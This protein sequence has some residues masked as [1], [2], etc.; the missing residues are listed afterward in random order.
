MLGT[1]ATDMI[2]VLQLKEQPC[3]QN[4]FPF[5]VGEKEIKL[6]DNMFD[7]SLRSPVSI[8][9]FFQKEKT[10]VKNRREKN[11]FV[12]ASNCD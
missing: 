12:N 11:Y 6:Y 9:L 10:I 8:Y 1:K 3:D 7:A 5:G 2:I 4:F